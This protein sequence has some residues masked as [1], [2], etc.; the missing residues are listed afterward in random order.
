MF[1]IVPSNL[2]FTNNLSTSSST[3]KTEINIPKLSFVCLILL[4]LK[5]TRIQTKIPEGYCKWYQNQK[6]RIS[7][8]SILESIYSC[9]GAKKQQHLNTKSNIVHITKL[10]NNIE[11]IM[12][13][14]FNIFFIN[15][16]KK[17]KMCVVFSKFISYIKTKLLSLVAP[18]DS[19]DT[20]SGLHHIVR[21]IWHN[22]DA[23]YT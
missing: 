19:P 16:K 15:L 2:T 12:R 1:N 17:K 21:L 11:F 3:F 13:I 22:K 6:I 8:V 4:L 7:T 5:N 14:I 10:I 18:T 9:V 23:K 20:P